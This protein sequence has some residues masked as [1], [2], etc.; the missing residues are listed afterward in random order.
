MA[1]KHQLTTCDAA[2]VDLAKQLKLPLA[3]RD[4]DMLRAATAEG[5]SVISA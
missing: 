4:K 3:S 5:I 1:R 2:Y